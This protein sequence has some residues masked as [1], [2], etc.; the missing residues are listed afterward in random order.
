MS[1]MKDA[2]TGFAGHRDI[3]ASGCV[4]GK[5]LNQGG[6]TGRTE[7]TG[8]GVVFKSVSVYRFSMGFAKFWK[9]L[10]YAIILMLLQE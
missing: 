4:T 5:A 2:Y 6:I 8:L 7:S 3:N 9:M 10:N 1:W